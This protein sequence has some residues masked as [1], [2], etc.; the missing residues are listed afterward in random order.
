MATKSVPEANTKS[1][2]KTEK[3]AAGK[4]NAQYVEWGLITAKRRLATAVRAVPL[5]VRRASVQQLSEWMHPEHTN[6]PDDSDPPDDECND[7]VA[8][9]PDDEHRNESDHS[10]DWGQPEI[11]LVEQLRK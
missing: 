5:T 7:H 2:P 1:A 11:V 9:Q 10:P 6:E 4:P 3:T 8:S